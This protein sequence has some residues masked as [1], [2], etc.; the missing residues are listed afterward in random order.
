[1]AISKYSILYSLCTIFNL[2]FFLFAASA[3]RLWNAAAS[4][5]NFG[6]HVIKKTLVRSCYHGIPLLSIGSWI[7]DVYSDYQ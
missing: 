6:T 3:I 7:I 2:E 1:M 4:F 5:V